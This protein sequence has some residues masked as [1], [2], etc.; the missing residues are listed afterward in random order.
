[1]RLSVAPPFPSLD[2]LVVASTQGKTWASLCR[3]LPGIGANWA[4]GLLS[5]PP[6]RR[7]SPRCVPRRTTQAILRGPSNDSITCATCSGWS[8]VVSSRESVTH[9]ITLGVVAYDMIGGRA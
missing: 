4:G 2:A 7:S 5:P 9:P 3:P 1:V 6:G 8:I